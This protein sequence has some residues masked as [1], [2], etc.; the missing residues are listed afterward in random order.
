MVSLFGLVTVATATLSGALAQEHG[1]PRHGALRHR[2]LLQE[3][4]ALPIPTSA[5]LP[6]CEL[7]CFKPQLQQDGTRAGAG[8]RH[9]MQYRYAYIILP[10]LNTGTALAL[11]HK[12]A[13][14][15]MVI[16]KR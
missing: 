15:A 13:Q 14:L 5:H 16:V 6:L 2:Q 9:G 8:R 4:A 12:Y 10:G 1:V 11:E 7:R 3:V